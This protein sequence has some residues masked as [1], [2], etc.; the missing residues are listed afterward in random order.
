MAGAAHLQARFLLQLVF[1]YHVGGSQAERVASTP[2]PFAIPQAAYLFPNI[3]FLKPI[4]QKSSQIWAILKRYILSGKL[5]AWRALQS[6][7]IT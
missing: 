5:D 7:T 2:T 3:F 4:F 6:L 1:C